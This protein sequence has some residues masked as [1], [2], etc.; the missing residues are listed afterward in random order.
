MSVAHTGLGIA[1]IAISILEP[2]T[3]ERDI[4]LGNGQSARV[5]AYDFK[6]IGTRNVDGP[7]YSATRAEVLV[8]RN[9]RTVTTLFPESREY[10]VRKQTESKAGMKN[11]Y[12]TDLKVA[13]GDDLGAG[14]W[15]MRAQV[16]PMITLLWLGPMLMALG[17]FCALSDRRYRLAR[18]AEGAPAAAVGPVPLGGAKGDTI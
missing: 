3:V 8:S 18:A 2:F 16:R 17:G 5:G 15:S 12:G 11:V 1:V 4:A 13:L 6:L 9:G 7:N 14:R 10:W